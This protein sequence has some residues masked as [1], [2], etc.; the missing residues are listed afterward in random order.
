MEERSQ[1][2]HVRGAKT[3]LDDGG[4]PPAEPR[5][6]RGPRQGRI[7]QYLRPPERR[8]VRCE[9]VDPEARDR[10]S[11]SAVRR[12]RGQGVQRQRCARAR[13]PARRRARD[14]AR[15]RGA[16]LR[17]GDPSTVAC[18]SRRST[19][20]RWRGRST[21][22]ATVSSSARSR[23]RCSSPFYRRHRCSISI[24]PSYVVPGTDV[25]G[26]EFA[27][28]NTTTALSRINYVNSLVYGTINPD[29]NVY[30][31]TGTS[32]NWSGLTALAGTPMRWSTSWTAAAARRAI[33]AVA[34]RD[35]GRG[36]GDQCRGCAGP[37]QGCVLS[38]R[39]VVAISS[40][41]LTWIAEPFSA[42]LPR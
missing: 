30:G 42:A 37:R 17:E 11:S 35:R 9:A 34:R 26:P 14:A 12:A 22:K 28:Q 18:A 24:L 10:Q 25:L 29:A 7:R 23:P 16:R 21:R 38:R 6:E 32:S 20:S 41:A 40:G 5:D 19:S 33:G 1:F 27:L 13:R 15:S 31:A 39:Y 2:H 8:T 36:Q 4:A 3:L